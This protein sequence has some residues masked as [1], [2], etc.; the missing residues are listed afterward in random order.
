MTV[1]TAGRMPAAGLMAFSLGIVQA[2]E[3]TSVEFYASLRTQVESVRARHSQ[4]MNNYSGMRDAFSRIGIKASH[5][6]GSGNQIFAQLEVPVDSANLEFR[7]PYDQGGSGRSSGQHLRLALAGLRSDA[8]QLVV[9]Q[10]WLPYYNAVAAPVDRFSS[11]YSGFSTYTVF[12]VANTVAYYSPAL[13]GF[14]FAAS[15]SAARGNLSS[16]SRIDARRVQ[17]TGSYAI[18]NTQFT[19]GMDDRG[20]AGYGRNRLYGIS[21]SHT[22]GPFYVALKYEYFDTGN[23]IPGSFASDGNHAVNLFGSY[24]VGRNTFKLMLADV[25]AYGGNIMHLGIDHQYRPDL[26]LFAEFYREDETATITARSGGLSD[27]DT[28]I[29]GGRAVIAGIRYDF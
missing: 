22:A 28:R 4:F 29:G 24:T 20:D 25:D 19:A 27:Y 3:T 21:A 7:D 15:W 8:G 23:K 5:D 26:K 13:H 11:Y 1:L 18:G 9:G 2:E 10:Q 14:S 17:L 6:L 16:T 12:R